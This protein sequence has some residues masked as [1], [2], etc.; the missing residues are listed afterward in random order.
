MPAAQ[1]EK[2]ARDGAQHRAGRLLGRVGHIL[3]LALGDVG[4]HVCQ[5]DDARRGD[6]GRIQRQ[7]GGIG[8]R[9]RHRDDA[10]A[11]MAA[12]LMVIT[13]PGGHEINIIGLVTQTTRWLLGLAGQAE[14]DEYGERCGPEKRDRDVS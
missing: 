7:P 2:R 12:E 13:K 8:E 3:F 11:A 14:G 4:G 9:V 10:I 5:R 6:A 1:F